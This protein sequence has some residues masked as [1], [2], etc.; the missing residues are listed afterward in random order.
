MKGGRLMK[1][2][3]PPTNRRWVACPTISAPRLRAIGRSRLEGLRG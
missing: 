3:S 2:V 1:G